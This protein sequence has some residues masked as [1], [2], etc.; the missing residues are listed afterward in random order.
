MTVESEG[1]IN[2]CSSHYLKTDA[3]HKA[4]A[5][6]SRS[7]VCA[8]GGVVDFTAHP[9]DAQDRHDVSLEH[10][11]GFDSQLPQDQ[12]RCFHEY[13]IVA[14]KGVALAEGLSPF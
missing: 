8:Y 6:S 5:A 2:P 7:Q 4:Q 12:G 13:I 14:D 1:L 11:D 3:V 10:A 9:N